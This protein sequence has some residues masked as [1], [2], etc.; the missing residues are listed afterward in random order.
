MLLVSAAVGA[1]AGWLGLV[2]S[3][4]VSIHHDTRLASGPTIVVVLTA[5]FALVATSRGV[6]RARLRRGD[7]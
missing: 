3:Y 2:I 1:F 5:L 4:D 6:Q 7:R